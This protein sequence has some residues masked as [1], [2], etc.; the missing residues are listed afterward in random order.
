MGAMEG[1]SIS[2][3][4]E[5]YARPPAI[6]LS[7]YCPIGRACAGVGLLCRYF[8]FGSSRIQMLR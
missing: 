8:L 5:R 4:S 3:R 6:R 2:R 1:A 7:A